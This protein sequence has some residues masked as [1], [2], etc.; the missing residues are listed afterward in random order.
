VIAALLWMVAARLLALID[1]TRV[2]AH[3]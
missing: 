2:D 3:S 1:L